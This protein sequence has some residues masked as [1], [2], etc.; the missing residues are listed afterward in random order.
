M[1][2]RIVFVAGRGGVGQGR[3]AGV[4]EQDR[5]ADMFGDGVDRHTESGLQLGVLGLVAQTR[6]CHGSQ[7]GGIPVRGLHAR[8][9]HVG[10][11]LAP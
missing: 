9:V 1:L 4:Y 10:V 2:T 5:T 3:A 6:S 8:T 11:K 7:V